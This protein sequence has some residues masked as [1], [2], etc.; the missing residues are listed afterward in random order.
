M[1][2]FEPIVQ[3]I[4][5]FRD[6][7]TF[8]LAMERRE[9]V[10]N[11]LQK[12]EKYDAIMHDWEKSFRKFMRQEKKKWKWY[13]RYLG[14]SRPKVNLPPELQKPPFDRSG[15]RPDESKDHSRRE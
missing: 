8:R 2:F 9:N 15:K 4:F 7:D 11:L 13:Q 1:V 12:I 5:N 14:I 10:E 3:S 6:Y